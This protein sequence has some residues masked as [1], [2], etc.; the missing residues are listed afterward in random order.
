[1]ANVDAY[2]KF[3]PRDY[4]DYYYNRIEDE[5]EKLLQFFYKAFKDL[6]PNTKMLEFGGGPTIYQLISAA[7]RVKSIDFSDYLE[8]NLDEVRQWLNNEPGQFAWREFFKRVLEIEGVKAPTK[9]QIAEREAM[10]KRKLNQLIKCNAFEAD[11]LGPKYRGYYDVVA[12]NFVPEG[13]TDSKKIW[14]EA[15]SHIVSM[16]KPGGLLEMA[17]ITGATYWMSG[18]Q[19]LPAV[20]VSEQDLKTLLVRLG[21]KITY[22]HTIPAEVLDETSPDYTGYTGMIFLTARKT[23]AIL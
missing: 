18:V 22:T 14:E 15:I 2:T 8:S 5:N 17:A 20:Y 4:L 6:K 19:K 21:L 12:V 10:L 16:L 23:Q 3:K 11:P 1:M 13:I 9:E 7:G